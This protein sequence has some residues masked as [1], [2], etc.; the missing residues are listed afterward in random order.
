MASGGG[1]DGQ[2]TSLFELPVDGSGPGADHTDLPAPTGLPSEPRSTRVASTVAPT[3]R[4]DRPSRLKIARRAAFDRLSRPKWLEKRSEERFWS[5]LGRFGVLRRVDFSVFP[6]LL[7]VSRPTRAK[8]R[9]HRKNPVKY[10]VFIGFSQD[11]G[12]LWTPCWP[13]NDVL[14][15]PNASSWP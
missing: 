3:S 7:R 9:R 2:F 12:F 8:K 10:K 11:R 14:G 13:W 15:D 1:R 5:I 4:F 6:M